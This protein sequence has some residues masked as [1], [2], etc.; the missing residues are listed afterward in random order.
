[1]TE[2]S[3]SHLRFT[4]PPAWVVRRFDDTAAYRSISGFG[5]K[6]VD[7]LCLAPDDQLWLIEV[8]NYR[9]RDPRHRTERRNP[10]GLAEHV[11]RKVTDSKRLIRILLRAMR[12]RWHLRLLFYWYRLSRSLSGRPRPT[13]HYWFWLEAD[14]RLEEARKVHVVLWLETPE[15]STDYRDAVHN[16]LEDELEPGNRLYLRDLH[17]TGEFPIRAEA[18]PE[19]D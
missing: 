8:K 16:H 14:R 1:V 4:F 13:F 9:R 3:E 12:K 10:K 17:T 15:R 18:A 19:V 7:F 11:G 2:L 6:G 5:L